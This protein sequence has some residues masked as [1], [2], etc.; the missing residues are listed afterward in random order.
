MKTLLQSAL[1]GWT[2]YTQQGKFVALLLLA[3]VYLGWRLSGNKDKTTA[4]GISVNHKWNKD[5][6][7][8]SETNIS[9]IDKKEI[10]KGGPYKWENSHTI[11]LYVYTILITLGCIFPVTALILMKYQTAF[12]SYVWIWAAVPQTTLI[13]WAG[14]E[15]LCDLW[16]SSSNVKTRDTG[17]A[18]NNEQS[19]RKQWL[20]NS[21]VTLLL[22]GIVFLS[23]NPVSDTAQAQTTQIPIPVSEEQLQHKQEPSAWEILE[24]LSVYRDMENS[25]TEKGTQNYC[26]WAPKDVMA[27]ARAFSA[28]IRPV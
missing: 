4:S 27:A 3:I 28:H 20:Q 2:T 21:V 12:Y 16:K 11:G 10:G 6:T 23:G 22:L 14:T 24:I 19:N 8:G 7:A 15:F 18:W 17:K 13:A 9:G 25:D 26:L 1:T 5:A